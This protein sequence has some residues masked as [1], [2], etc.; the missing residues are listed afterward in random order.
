MRHSA[1][2][3]EPGDKESYLGGGWCLWSAFEGRQH[4]AAGV[5]QLQGR[6]V[7]PRPRSVLMERLRGTTPPIG[8][9]PPAGGLGSRAQATGR[10]LWS[11]RGGRLPPSAGAHQQSGR[12]V[13]PSHRLVP[14][15]R[16]QGIASSSVLGPPARGMVSPA[17]VA[18]GA[19]GA[20]AG[21]G[22]PPGRGPT[23]WADGDPDR[24]GLRLWSAYGGRLP[25]LARAHQL[26]GRGALPRRRSVPMA[27]LPRTGAPISSGPRA[28]GTGK[29]A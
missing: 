27:P 10:C 9:G 19:Y 16:L 18:V 20:P 4:P 23:S 11:A 21:D 15:E 24:R 26:G 3:H 29:L 17:Q 25:P 14:M 22:C 5:H 13:L 2:V 12:G 28:S 6:G 1:W 8:P 7:L